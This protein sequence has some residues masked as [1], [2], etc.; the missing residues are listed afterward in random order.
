MLI[1]GSRGIAL[2]PSHLGFVEAL[3]CLTP[4]GQ[5]SYLENGHD[6]RCGGSLRLAYCDQL[7]T[8]C[9]AQWG[10]HGHLFRILI[11]RVAVR[12]EI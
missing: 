11:V 5:S 6:C 7:V 12:R 4:L 9:L 1:T 2:E 3:G 8:F 10:G